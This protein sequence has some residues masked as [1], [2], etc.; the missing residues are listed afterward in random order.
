MTTIQRRLNERARQFRVA[1]GGGSSSAGKSLR[2]GLQA[3]CRHRCI[4][5]LTKQAEKIT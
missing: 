4:R 1:L 5:L 3:Q 2:L